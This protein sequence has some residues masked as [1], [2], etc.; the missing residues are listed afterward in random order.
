MAKTE[1]LL[2]LLK[3]YI[4]V[5]THVCEYSTS[6]FFIQPGYSIDWCL[7]LTKIL[8]TLTANRQ[9]CAV[10]LQGTEADIVR[11]HCGGWSEEVNSCILFLS[12]MVCL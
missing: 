11:Y 6:S 10:P 12:Y 8:L 9:Q 7:T 1:V 3:I 4:Q 2:L 5:C